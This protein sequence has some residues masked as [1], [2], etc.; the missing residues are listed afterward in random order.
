[1]RAGTVVDGRYELVELL[2]Q[3]GFGQVW[4]ARDL[5]IGRPVAVKVAT[6]GSHQ[7]LARLH[8]EAALAG[9][10]SHPNIVVVHDFGTGT[11]DDGHRYAYLVMELLTGE[12]LSELL[13]KEGPLDL[14]TT[15]GVAGSV[16]EALAA[17]HEA[18]L[19]HRDIKPPNIMI[20][21][22]VKVVD[23][24]I[25]KG[26]DTRHDLTG[27]GVTIGSP[28][29]MAPECFTGTFSPRSDWYS[30]G[31]VIHEMVAGQPPFPGRDFGDLGRQ[32][33]GE[34]PPR[35]RALRPDTPAELDELAATL[36][37]KNPTHRLADARAITDELRR[38]YDRHLGEHAPRQ[39]RDVTSEIVVRP[40]AAAAGA[41]I[42][43]RFTTS[44]PCPD[45]GD[46]PGNKRPGGC[47]VCDGSGHLRTKQERSIRLAADVR[48]GQRVRLK[49]LGEAGKYGGEPGDMYITVR[50]LPPQEWQKLAQLHDRFIS[51]PADDDAAEA[52]TQLLHNG[53]PT[54]MTVRFTEVLPDAADVLNRGRDMATDVTL[55]PDDAASG[56]VVRIPVM[57]RSPCPR[58]PAAPGAPG[59]T[60]Q[61]CPG[62]R[63]TGWIGEAEVRR[64]RIP[65]GIQDMQKLRIRGLGEPGSNGGPSGDLYVT[66][67]V[68]L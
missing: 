15:L 62:C 63:G 3:G 66:V 17:A 49:G 59:E 44:R 19:V 51:R 16:A 29:Y 45:C 20:G 24:G 18:G 40:E 39:G 52:A 43:V 25:T 4:R 64:V 46:A 54:A 5:R 21:D 30:L 26:T 56:R 34:P 28:A 10:L 42:P 55:T 13:K 53:D 38:I 11:R 12:S 23:F 32:H 22:D 68:R 7:E 67:H 14:L 60:T 31:C 41:A 50:L 2:G 36:L 33:R 27:V 1:M 35:L 65:P 48:D 9:S 6:P 58:C 8:R 57:T 37:A 47:L 61:E